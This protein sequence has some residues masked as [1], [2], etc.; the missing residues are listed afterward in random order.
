MH[1]ALA[2]DALSITMHEMTKLIGRTYKNG[3]NVKRCL[4]EMK[5]IALLN[6]KPDMGYGR[7]TS[8]KDL[9]DT[10]IFEYQIHKYI[11]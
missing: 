10:N 8:S 3:S 9:V 11:N 4:G 7:V 5:E 6:P 1:V 2:I